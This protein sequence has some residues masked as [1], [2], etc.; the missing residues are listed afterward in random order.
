MGPIIH[1]TAPWFT[2]DLGVGLWLW[3]LSSQPTTRRDMA[4]T[5]LDTTAK[6]HPLP[7]CFIVAAEVVPA[8]LPQMVKMCATEAVHSEVTER[9]N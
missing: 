3:D 2:G 6:I 9:D 1:I 4:T 5:H 7:H 8:V